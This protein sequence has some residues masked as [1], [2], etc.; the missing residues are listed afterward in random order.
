M[1]QNNAKTTIHVTNLP[2]DKSSLWTTFADLPGFKR[3]SFHQDFCFVCFDEISYATQ[4]IDF[5]QNSVSYSLGFSAPIYS[6]DGNQT[7]MVASYAKHGLSSSN[8]SSINTCPNRILYMSLSP[9]FMERQWNELLRTYEGFEAIKFFASYG[10]ARFS[11]IECAT[12]A[13][14]DILE[15]TNLSITYSKIK[16]ASSDTA[17]GEYLTIS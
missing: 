5:V 10:L 17:S 11:S 14:E 3:V 4:A 1:S 16:L 7:S 2:E 12:D 8:A 13:L 9:F 15:R 6:W